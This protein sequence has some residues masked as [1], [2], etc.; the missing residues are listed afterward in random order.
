MNYKSMR[1]WAASVLI[2]LTLAVQPLLTQGQSAS[3]QQSGCKLFPE[4][5]KQ[6]CGK[7]LA[8]W[9]SHGGLAQQGYPLSGEF[10]EV[11]DTD[12]KSYTVQY[13]ERAV[14]EMHPEN[15]PPND[16]LLALLG[17][18]AYRQ[19]YPNGAPEL[20][21]PMNPVAGMFFAQTGKEIRG[22]FLDYWKAHGGL[23]QQ[24]YPITNLLNEKNLMDGKTYTVQYFERAVLEMHPENQPPYNVLLSQLGSFRFKGRYPNGD[25]SSATSPPSGNSWDALSKRPLKIGSQAPGSPCATSGSAMV[26]PEYATALGDGPA[27]P[28]GF[29][30]DGT[31]YYGGTTPEGGWFL[32]KVLWVG[33]PEVKGP[34]LVRGRQL[35]GPNE[36][37]FGSGPNPT[38]ELRLSPENSNSKSS[39]GWYD[40][41]SYTRLRAPGC[42][43]YQVDGA[44]FSKVITFRALNEV[45]PPPRR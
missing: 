30:A 12:G 14:F 45:P 13:F 4:T 40:W 42:Y 11:S 17:S 9:T 8:Y 29:A 26:M 2:L 44:N 20:P 33:S 22:V 43:A 38:N 34:V 6:I 36:L 28:V 3:A 10:S 7:F 1:L 27:Y 19:R 23:A 32:L 16:V 37:R 21:P 41:P 24:G 39:A 31:Y 35:D 18:M 25:P 15:Q 5:G